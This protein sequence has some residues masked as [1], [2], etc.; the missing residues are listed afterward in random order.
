MCTLQYV[1]VVQKDLSRLLLELD[2]QYECMA[3]GGKGISPDRFASALVERGSLSTQAA[4]DWFARLDTTHDGYVSAF[5]VWN[6]M[7]SNALIYS[8]NTN[9]LYRFVTG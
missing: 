9:L 2:A 3:A 8:L 5:F 7:D 6:H 4:A 1:D